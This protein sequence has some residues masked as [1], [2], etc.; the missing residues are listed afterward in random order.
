M[1]NRRLSKEEWNGKNESGQ[2]KGSG[3]L[4]RHQV[5]KECIIEIGNEG[6]VEVEI[7]RMVQGEW[8]LQLASLKLERY[9]SAAWVSQC[10]PLLIY[11]GA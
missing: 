5:N 3:L 10:H 2:R 11:N 6:V 1:V 7:S 8:M 9:G 4:S